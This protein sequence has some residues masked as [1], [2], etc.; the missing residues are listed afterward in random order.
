[1]AGILMQA[2]HDWRRAAVE[3][4]KIKNLTSW[5]QF[6]IEMKK[7]DYRKLKDAEDGKSYVLYMDIIDFEGEKKKIKVMITGTHE[8][9]TTIAGPIPYSFFQSII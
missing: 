8:K 4:E 5:D 9:P 1:M 2:D 3:E 7:Y 6:L